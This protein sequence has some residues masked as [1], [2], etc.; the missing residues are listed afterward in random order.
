R[1]QNDLRTETLM[2]TTVIALLS[3]C[4]A[5]AALGQWEP[6][7]APHVA[8]DGGDPR[9]YYAHSYYRE[10]PNVAGLDDRL[11]V[12]VQNFANLLKEAGGNCSNVILFINGMPIKGLKPESCDVKEGH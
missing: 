5:A 7:D 1:W 8:D 12:H 6:P 3:L 2:R 4:T 11:S 10:T 9:V